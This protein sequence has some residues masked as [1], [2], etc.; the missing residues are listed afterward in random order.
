MK[1]IDDETIQALKAAA[2]TKDQDVAITYENLV[3][4]LGEGHIRKMPGGQLEVDP[5]SDLTSFFKR[6][7]LAMAEQFESGP[8]GTT[9]RLWKNDERRT[10]QEIHGKMY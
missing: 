3:G 8:F 6:L 5:A 4:I 1:P 2:G 10:E 7:P 9:L